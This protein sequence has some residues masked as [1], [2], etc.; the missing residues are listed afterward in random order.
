MSTSNTETMADY[1]PD[2]SGDQVSFLRETLSAIS[3]YAATLY[4]KPSPEARLSLVAQTADAVSDLAY[5]WDWGGYDNAD[6]AKDCLVT[7]QELDAEAPELVSPIVE[8]LNAVIARLDNQGGTN[9]DVDEALEE[10][11]ALG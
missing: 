9:K 11:E 1:R 7:L 3:T 4:S 8:Q 5:A 2:I 6:V 10:E